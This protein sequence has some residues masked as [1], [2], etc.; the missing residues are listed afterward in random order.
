MN[1]QVN[2]RFVL[3]LRWME[4]TFAERSL[5]LFCFENGNLKRRLAFER[6]IHTII[7]STI[8]VNFEWTKHIRQL[9]PKPIDDPLKIYKKTLLNS[10]SHWYS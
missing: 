2:S 3:L 4:I 9:K 1:D 8:R 5:L 10:V 7:I 6:N